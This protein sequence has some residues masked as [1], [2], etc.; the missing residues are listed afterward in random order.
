MQENTSSSG[1]SMSGS[2][3]KMD[4]EGE[5]QRRVSGTMSKGSSSVCGVNLEMPLQGEAPV[6]MK[7]MVLWV[8]VVGPG[9]FSY[10]TVNIQR[11]NPPF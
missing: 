1:S 7:L 8:D 10:R 3:G 4:G 9:R 11:T 5:L 6:L 2:L